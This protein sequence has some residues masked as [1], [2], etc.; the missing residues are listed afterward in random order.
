MI[1]NGHIPV[2]PTPQIGSLLVACCRTI[3]GEHIRGEHIH[4]EHI[5]GEHI[6]GEHMYDV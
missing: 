2:A 3:R 5:R 6:H 4:G 1:D